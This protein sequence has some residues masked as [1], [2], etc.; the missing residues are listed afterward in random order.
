MYLCRINNELKNETEAQH[1][2]PIKKR[3]LLRRQQ[4]VKKKLSSLNIGKY[5]DDGKISKEVKQ[6]VDTEELERV[7]SDTGMQSDKLSVKK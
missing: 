7:C 6:E 3:A 2:S 5:A 4:K 1:E